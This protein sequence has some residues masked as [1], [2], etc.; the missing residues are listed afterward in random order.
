MTWSCR[1]SRRRSRTAVLQLFGS[2][3]AEAATWSGVR[4]PR[5]AR[6]MRPISAGSPVP[7]RAARN[8]T[9]QVLDQAM[10]GDHGLGA[11]VLLLGPGTVAL[12]DHPVRLP[13]LRRSKTTDH[14][15][16]RVVRPFLGACHEGEPPRCWAS[17]AH[18]GSMQ[19]CRPDS[20]S[21]CRSS[22]SSGWS[23]RRS[24]PCDDSSSLPRAVRAL[25]A[26]PGVLPDAPMTSVRTHPCRRFSP[27]DPRRPYPPRPQHG[28][29]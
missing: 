28:P 16:G 27:P 13:P 9:R 1:R 25:R 14:G 2:W 12:S 18:S 29:R 6:R 7:R 3:R 23:I 8:A 10:P 15:H 19:Q 24:L 21:G 4:S 5:P 20:L 26:R 11:A 17:P 22:R